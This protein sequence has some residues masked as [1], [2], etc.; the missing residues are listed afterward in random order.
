MSLKIIMAVVLVVSAV[1]GITWRH[2]QLTELHRLNQALRD[3]KEQAQQSAAKDQAA[4]RVSPGDPSVAARAELKTELLRLR[5]EVRQLRDRQPELSRLRAENERIAAELRSG[6]PTVRRLAEMEGFIPRQDW[7]N[8]GFATPEAAARSFL[9]AIASADLDQFIRC[10]SP[11]AADE[12]QRQIQKDP[13]GFRKEFQE[14][15]GHF[16]KIAGFRIAERRQV[17]ED[18]IVLSLQVAAD[19]Q[20]M[21]LPLRRVDNEWKLDKE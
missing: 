7:A 8:A 18:R 21:P 20:V 13:E 2:C 6:K 12:F 14:A 10:A 4:Q 1:A 19:G 11:E 15:F 9:A 3:Q 5:N 17:A 16:D